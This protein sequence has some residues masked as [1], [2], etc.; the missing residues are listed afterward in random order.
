MNGVLFEHVDHRDAVAGL[1]Y[2]NRA[3]V[4]EGLGCLEVHAVLNFFE[5]VGELKVIDVG[6]EVEPVEILRVEGLRR[7][8]VSLSVNGVIEDYLEVSLNGLHHEGHIGP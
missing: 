6:V 8:E 5:E 4:V 1:L 3:E 2:Q 7:F